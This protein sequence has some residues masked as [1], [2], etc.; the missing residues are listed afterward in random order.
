M[1]DVFRSR[2]HFIFLTSEGG[3]RF[4][5]VN[6][7]KLAL[8]QTRMEATRPA[9][10]LKDSF[11]LFKYK[12]TAEEVSFEWSHHRISLADSTLEQMVPCK[13]TAEEVLFEWSHHRI[14]SKDS[15]VRKVLHYMSPYLTL[16]MK[17]LMVAHLLSK[18]V[19]IQCNV[20]LYLQ[21]LH[22][23]RVYKRSIDERESRMFY[24]VFRG[25]FCC[26]LLTVTEAFLFEC[27]HKKFNN[28]R[29]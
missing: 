7:L 3:K 6:G 27:S 25:S 1:Q 15:K 13:S 4:L 11:L 26:W 19:K 9:R 22:R 17:G 10:E 21:Q 29:R 24:V 23:E 2:N 5:T 28:T 14:F 18:A 12:S 16:G 8:T 20:L